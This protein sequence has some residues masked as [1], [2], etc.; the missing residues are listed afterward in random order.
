MYVWTAVDLEDQLGEIKP[1]VRAIEREL[2]FGDSALTLPFHISLKISFSVSD[3]LYP[4]VIDTLFAYL[5]TVKPFDVHVSSIEMENSIVWI[6]MKENTFLRQMH[7]DLDGILMERH[8]I[9]QH[10]YDLDFKFHTTLFLDPD[11]EKIRAAYFGIKELPIPA[12]LRANSLLI[13]VSES[14]AIGTYR[15]THRIGMNVD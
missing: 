11:G 9:R 12:T 3:E 10:P 4:D 1:Q 6:R 2:G 14:G 13:G 5:R 15:V 8:G 7:A